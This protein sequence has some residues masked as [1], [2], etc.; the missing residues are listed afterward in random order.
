MPSALFALPPFSDLDPADSHL[1]VALMSVQ[2]FRRSER[3][4]SADSDRSHIFVVTEGRLRACSV[5]SPGR[6]VTL[7]RYGT[8]SVLGLDNLVSALPAAVDTVADTDGVLLRAAAHQ[9]VALM[10]CVPRL[11]LIL[12]SEAL[13][14]LHDAEEFA[15]RLSE[16]SVE[17][18]VAAALLEA[19]IPPEGAPA[20][21]EHLASRAAAS[22]ESVSR[23][24]QR[25]AGQGVLELPGRRVRLR[26]EE[27]LR[28][29]A[30]PGNGVRHSASPRSTL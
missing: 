5:N 12:L 9:V 28:C 30:S 25:L 21:R 20:S 14:Q 7:R 19:S 6:E 8:G 13:R 15:C 2:S 3:V 17:Q 23:T 11:G 1:L 29:L 4:L 27:A 22:R 16:S 26:D 10:G 18:R 24:L